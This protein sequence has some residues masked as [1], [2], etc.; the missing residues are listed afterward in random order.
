VR[1]AR[2]R[3]AL[4]AL[5]GL[6]LS[7]CAAV[8]PNYRTPAAAVVNAPA[9]KA[10]FK[11]AA[12]SA[13]AQ[14][15]PPD[16]WWRLYKDP[17]LDRLVEQALA[18]NT[19][20]HVAEANLERSEA[21]LRAA[22]AARQPDVTVNYGASDTER[23]AAAYVHKGPIPTAGLYDTGLAVSYDLDLFGR[24]RRGVEAAS[25]QTEAFRAARDLARVNVAAETVRAYAEVC[26]AGAET[27]AT[28]HVIELQGRP[29]SAAWPAA[30]GT[31]RSASQGS[32][33]RRTS[34]A[35]GSPPC[36][37]ARPTPSI[38]SPSS[39]AG[40][41][42][43]STPRSRTAAR[44]CRSARRC[45]WAMARACCGGVRT[46]APPSGAWL[47][48]SPRSASTWRRSIPR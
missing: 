26:D 38:A 40:R 7:A 10:P 36:R 12:A 32:R 17:T 2:F 35:P 24:L 3:P 37:R 23:S 13:F 44:L 15:D 9:A 47:R 11:S 20:L 22:R 30:A 41:R 6:T 1:A 4:A 43:P 14:Q 5:A 27:A 46:C 34:S 28:E 21:L 18:A 45:R 31:S 39:P 33:R 16:H 42:G 48:L 25:A 29:W 8:G 19:D